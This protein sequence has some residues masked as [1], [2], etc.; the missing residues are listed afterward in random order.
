MTGRPPRAKLAAAPLLRWRNFVLRMAVSRELVLRSVSVLLGL[1]RIRLLD[2]RT[3]TQGTDGSSKA[4]AND[5]SGYPDLRR[6]IR[7]AQG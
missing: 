4:I 1:S 7:F 5:S 2:P 6:V 3:K